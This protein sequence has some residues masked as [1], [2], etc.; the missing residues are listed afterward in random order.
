MVVADSDV[1]PRAGPRAA[2]G[3]A[4]PCPSFTVSQPA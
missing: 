2:D 1:A 3:R 4:D